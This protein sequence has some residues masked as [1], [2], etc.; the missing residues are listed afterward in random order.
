MDK[1]YSFL[2]G[3]HI[4]PGQA[5]A[6]TESNK[7]Q[8]AGWF[9]TPFFSS[10]R[11]HMYVRVRFKVPICVITFFTD[12]RS[13]CG[14]H[15]QHFNKQRTQLGGWNA[16]V[17]LAPM[18]PKHKPLMQQRTMSHVE[19]LRKIS[20]RV[21]ATARQPRGRSSVEAAEMLHTQTEAASPSRTR[22]PPKQQRTMRVSHVIVVEQL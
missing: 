16:V 18:K 15:K 22:K 8:K 6:C 17:L 2:G 5:K 7:C 13:P 19:Q 20:H 21:K 1:G 4:T 9:W 10:F 14:Q 3:A 12:T 11:L